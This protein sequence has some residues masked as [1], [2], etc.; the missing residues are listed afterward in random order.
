MNSTACT[1]SKQGLVYASR[2]R[3]QRGS[4]L[5]EYT[6]VVLFLVVVLVANPNLIH[7]LGVAIRDAYTSF[8][9]ALSVSWI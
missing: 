3:R 5:V 7:Q 2:R 4:A 9:Y 6:V 1:A 8:V